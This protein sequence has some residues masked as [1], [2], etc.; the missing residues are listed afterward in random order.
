MCVTLANTDEKSESSCGSRRRTRTRK[1]TD[2]VGQVGEEKGERC[3]FM[4]VRL[5]KKKAKGDSSCGSGWRRKRRKVTVHVGQVGLPQLLEREEQHKKNNERTDKESTAM[6]DTVKA[7]EAGSINTGDLIK[8]RE[9]GVRK[10]GALPGQET[11][12]GKNKETESINRKMAFLLPPS[13]SAS[14]YGNLHDS[15]GKAR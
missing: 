9:Q 11:T 3:H 5:A 8:S 15:L 10:V 14:I 12:Q 4:W 2:H 6:T 13:H 7:T 1:V